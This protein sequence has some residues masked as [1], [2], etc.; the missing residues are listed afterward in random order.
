M[1]TK[2]S[3]FDLRKNCRSWRCLPIILVERGEVRLPT[4]DQ[5][6]ER[7]VPRNPL[8]DAPAGFFGQHTQ[9]IFARNDFVLRPAAV[10]NVI[11]WCHRCM[12]SLSFNRLRRS[13]VLTVFKGTSR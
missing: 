6:R 12:H 8:L 7:P 2:Q 4:F 3:S 11:A 1:R 5:Q 13:Q 10:L 9:D